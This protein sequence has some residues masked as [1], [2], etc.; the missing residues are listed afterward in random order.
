[1]KSHGI[2]HNPD[3][4]KLQDEFPGSLNILGKHWPVEWVSHASE[5]SDGTDAAGETI[6]SRQTIRVMEGQAFD[7]ERDTLIHEPL[8]AIDHD[9]QLGLKEKQVH[10]LASAL[11]QFMRANPDWVAHIMAPHPEESAA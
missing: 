11:Y 3:A 10:R 2:P 4:E 6:F 1:M 7:A 9:M 5:F 8:H